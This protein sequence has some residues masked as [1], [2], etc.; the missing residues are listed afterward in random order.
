MTA[1]IPL[2]RLYGFPLRRPLG[3]LYCLLLCMELT[4]CKAPLLLPLPRGRLPPL[5]VPQR[6]ASVVPGL[7]G[8]NTRALLA[9]SSA[10]LPHVLEGYPK[11]KSV[12]TL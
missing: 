6:L 7:S 4:T 5:K 3:L 2:R 8:S 11:I 12:E 10:E 1:S 9:V